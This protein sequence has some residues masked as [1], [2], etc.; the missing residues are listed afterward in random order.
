MTHANPTGYH[1][2]NVLFIGNDV[3]QP[4]AMIDISIGEVLYDNDS[5]EILGV[6]DTGSVYLVRKVDGTWQGSVIWQDTGALYAVT[7][8]DFL[9]GRGGDEIIVAGESGAVT[10]L[11]L[12][13]PDSLSQN[14][15]V[16]LTEFAQ[17]AHG[18]KKTNPGADIS[19]WPLGNGIV[20]LND[21][22]VIIENWLETSYWL[23][24]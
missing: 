3:E 7:V 21:L 18:W 20:D 2:V 24:E 1:D 13:F 11:A 22:A 6:D 14:G 23:E 15:R 9:P 19:P 17:V 5:L 10:L 8:G 4:L 16:E 12:T